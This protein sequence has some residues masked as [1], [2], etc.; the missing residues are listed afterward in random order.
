MSGIGLPGKAS[1]HRMT[2]IK[3]EA[4][5]QEQEPG[6]RV[7]NADHFVVLG[8]HVLL[9][10]TELVMVPVVVHVGV[11]RATITRGSGHVVIQRSNS[12]IRNGVP[13]GAGRIV[14]RRHKRV[15]VTHR[16]AF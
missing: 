3:D 7:L 9:P 6:D 1:C 13:D 8:E 10:E 2:I 15:Q 12:L 14:C 16:R 5:Q 4:E 11:M